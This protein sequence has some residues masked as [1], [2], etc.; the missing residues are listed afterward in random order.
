MVKYLLWKEWPAQFNTSPMQKLSKIAK[1]FHPS[2]IESLR[3]VGLAVWLSQWAQ[4][5]VECICLLAFM[6]S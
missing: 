4:G 1:A 3:P 2:A 5:S 6:K